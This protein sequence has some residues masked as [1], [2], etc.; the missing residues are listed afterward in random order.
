MHVVSS[1]NPT[2]ILLCFS[3]TSSIVY[4]EFVSY[5]A[6][7]IALLLEAPTWVLT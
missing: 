5:W 1:C 7:S 4:V 6:R 2:A 3:T